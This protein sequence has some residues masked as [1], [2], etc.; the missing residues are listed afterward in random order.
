[1]QDQVANTP[2]PGWVET[3]GILGGDLFVVIVLAVV[4]YIF[5]EIVTGARQERRSNDDLE[6]YIDEIEQDHFYNQEEDASERS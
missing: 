1:M 4:C 2:F 5:I 6:E 3:I